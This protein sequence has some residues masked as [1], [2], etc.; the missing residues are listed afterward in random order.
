MKKLKV[1]FHE[2]KFFKFFDKTKSSLHV[3]KEAVYME[4]L[5]PNVLD[6]KKFRKSPGLRQ[7]RLQK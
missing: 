4:L 1:K 2:F 3:D 5:N 7:P 6:Q